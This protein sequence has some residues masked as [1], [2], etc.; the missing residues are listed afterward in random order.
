MII[1]GK[2]FIVTGFSSDLA[3][4]ALI[5]FSIN[6]KIYGTY[7]TNKIDVNSNNIYLDELDLNDE[8]AIKNYVSKI[9]NQLSKI[10]VINLAAYKK[11][12]LLHN[13]NKTDLDQTFSVNVYSNILLM[14]YLTPIM[15]NNKWG[16]I[17]HISSEKAMRGSIG[18]TLYSSSKSALQ[19]LNRGIAKEYARFGITSNIINLGYFDSGLFRKLPENTKKEFINS[20][21]TKKLGSPEDIYSCIC[22]LISSE[23]TNGSIITIDGC[24]N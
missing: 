24:M 5:D 20:I 22:F 12:S 19:G 1:K 7:R 8:S 4:K 6:N 9:K 21:P 17:I 14:K 2:Q 10:V 23:F 16:R 3:N 18:A 13:I 15:I 11:D